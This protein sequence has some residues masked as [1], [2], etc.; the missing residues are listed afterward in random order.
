MNEERAKIT[1][2]KDNGTK[3][4]MEIVS[5][6]KME[7]FNKNYIIYKSIVDNKYFAASFNADN[8]NIDTNLS[9]KE[10]EALEDYFK[11]YVLGGNQN[12]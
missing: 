6:F 2:V 3:E 7:A 11:L 9:D 8:D 4:E 12:A 5:I 1:V 10:K